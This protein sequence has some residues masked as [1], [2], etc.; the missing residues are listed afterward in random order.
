MRQ[1]LGQAYPICSSLRCE[2][3]WPRGHTSRPL[4]YC[5]AY[6]SSSTL[7]STEWR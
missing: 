7:L 4:I 2:Q 6:L 3:M 5:F 1:D